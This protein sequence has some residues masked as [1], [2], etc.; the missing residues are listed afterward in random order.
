MGDWA[1]GYMT[2]TLGLEPGEGYGWAASPGTD[3]I[4]MWLSDSFGLPVGAPN[5]DNT[6]AWLT[7][8][9]SVEGQD[10]FNPL[11]GSIP[12]RVDADTGNTDLYNAYLQ[13]AAEDWSMNTLASSL[14]HGAAANENFMNDFNS[15]MEIYLQSRSAEAAGAAL[16]EV[17]DQSGACGS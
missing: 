12:A 1:A 10:A 7:L 13:S 2:T 3:G 16:V 11:K 9:G 8:M 14:A 17:C 6:L 5:R 4:F 15:V